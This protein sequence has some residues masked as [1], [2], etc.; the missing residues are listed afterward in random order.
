M[1][2][3]IRFKISSTGEVEMDVQGAVGSECDSLTEGFEGVLGNVLSKER[4]DSYFKTET[5][6]EQGLETEVGNE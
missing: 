6:F 1:V 3:Q 2:K 5:S 4:K